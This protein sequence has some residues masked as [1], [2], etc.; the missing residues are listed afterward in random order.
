VSAA[1]IISP[2]TASD[3]PLAVPTGGQLRSRQRIPGY[4]W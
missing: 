1:K 3:S 4:G 2:W